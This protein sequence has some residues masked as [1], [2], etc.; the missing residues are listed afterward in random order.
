MTIILGINGST[1]RAGLFRRFGGMHNAA[2]CILKDGEL[3]AFVEEER[4]NQIK[5]F[6]GFPVASIRYC[7]ETAGISLEEVDQIA[8]GWMNL[9]GL[10]WDRLST[11]AANRLM[12][13]VHHAPV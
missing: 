5:Q 3:L 10:L 9:P 13:T 8:Y 1:L 2:A 12:F 6:G 7:L 4:F 11:F